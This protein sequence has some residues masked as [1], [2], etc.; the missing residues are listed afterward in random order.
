MK[1]LKHLLLHLWNSSKA[2]DVIA[3]TFHMSQHHGFQVPTFW[4]GIMLNNIQAS[5]KLPCFC[6][7]LTKDTPYKDIKATAILNNQVISMPPIFWCSQAN[8]C[9][10]MHR[11]N[12]NLSW[13][14]PFH[15]I[16]WNKTSCIHINYQGIPP[17]KHQTHN[18]FE[19]FVYKH[20]CTLQV[21]LNYHMHW[22]V[23]QKSMCMD[24]FKLFLTL[25]GTIALPSQAT[26]PLHIL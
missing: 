26:H 16:S 24:S 2:L 4:D 23:Q 3:S 18:T 12:L 14:I 13:L 15:Y 5:L 10:L 8:T 19:L 11:T 20:I 6:I 25:V 17:H 22:L 9:M 21:L 7:N 1:R